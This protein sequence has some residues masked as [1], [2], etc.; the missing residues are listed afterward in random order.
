MKKLALS[1]I[2]EHPAMILRKGDFA[3]WRINWN[4]KAANLLELA[5]E[6]NLGLDSFVFLDDSPW[7]G[8]GP[9]SPNSTPGVYARFARLACQLR[10]VPHL[11][12]LLRDSHPGKRRL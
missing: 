8:A 3:A 4:D 2:E 12:E 1:T 10:T 9:G 11:V 6:L 7:S 5:E